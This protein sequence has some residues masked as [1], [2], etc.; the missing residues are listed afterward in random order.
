MKFEPV[1][2]AAEFVHE[3]VAFSD[4]IHHHTDQNEQRSDDTESVTVQSARLKHFVLRVVKP[5]FK[6]SDVV[7]ITDN[8]QVNSGDDYNGGKCEDVNF[9]GNRRHVKV[10]RQA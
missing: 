3:T 5:F 8:R 10:F 2:E 7:G 6:W 9:V 1:L 4:D